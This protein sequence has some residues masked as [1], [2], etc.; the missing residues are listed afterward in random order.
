[1]G[2]KD[3][4]KSPLNDKEIDSDDSYAWFCTCV[5]LLAGIVLISVGMTRDLFIKTIFGVF[6][7]KINYFRSLNLGRF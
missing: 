3:K 1:M 7:F 6:N 4:K 2:K 5:G